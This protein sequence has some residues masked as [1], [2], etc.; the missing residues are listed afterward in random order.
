MHR[1]AVSIFPFFSQ[2]VIS[3]FL[4]VALVLQSGLAEVVKGGKYLR[5]M[6]EAFLDSHFVTEDGR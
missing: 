6:V 2:S 5:R 1:W 4:A 3:E